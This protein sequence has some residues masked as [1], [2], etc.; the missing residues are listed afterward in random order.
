MSPHTNR[1]NFL[2]LSAAGVAAGAAAGGAA[3]AGAVEPSA[4]S[5]DVTTT[6]RPLQ[7]HQLRLWYP[8][9]A[10]EW[11]EALPIGNGR[12]GA[13]VFGGV[14]SE[15]LQLNEDTVWAGGPYDP[16]NPDGLANLQEIR[17]RVFAG[18]WGG[19]QS[20]ID[21]SF[22]GNPL[23]E[24]P[25]QTVGNLTLTFP[26]G[27]AATDYYR[28]LDL[29][30]A[31][32]LTRYARDGVTYTREA[33][34][35]G[36][37]QVIVVRL[38]ADATGSVSFSAAFDSPQNSSAHSPDPLTIGLDGTTEDWEGVAG[39]VRFRALATVRNTGGTVTSENGTL[40]VDGAD[41]V[42]VLISIGANYT[43]FQDLTGDQDARALD[44][45]LTAGDRAYDVLR[46]RH[47]EDYQRFFNRVALDVGT[48]DA[49]EL[50]TD[51]RVANFAAADDP[52]LVALL[53]QFGRYLLIS[54]SRP[55]TQPANLQGIWNESLSPD[56]DSKYTVNINAEM[57]YWPAGPT[58][59]VEMMEPALQMV[60]EMSVTGARTA[61]VQYGAEGWVCHHNTDAWRGTA[62]VD[63]AQWGMYQTGGAW[64]A[65]F[66]WEHYRFTGD[67]DAL[68]A[69]YPALKGAARF[70]VDALVEDPGTG[71][72]V[73][74]PSNS[75]EN[76]HHPGATVCAGP[77]MDMQ[78]LR[79]LFN[80]VAQAS[81]LLETDADFREQV[82]ALSDRLAPTKVGGQGQIQEWQEDWDAGAPERNHRHVSHLYGLH[83]SNQI[84]PTGTPELAEAARVT[85]EQRGD[86]GTGWSL[87]WKIN[88]WARLADGARSYKLLGDQLTPDRTA[89]NLF[90]LHP[91]FQI[92]G[93][94]GATAG[95]AEWLLQSHTDEIQLLPALPPELPDGQVSGLRARGGDTID[96]TWENGEITQATL[97]TRHARTVQ[98]RTTVPVTVTAADGGRQVTARR[99]DPTTVTFDATAGA[100]YR[101]TRR[102]GS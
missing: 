95:I 34:A 77:T 18:D 9:E 38:T 78:I 101:L 73:T 35:S 3:A 8:G 96:I 22:M 64:M 5:A 31:V 16:A 60:E 70:F 44:P 54:S 99:T 79:D 62:P 67:L 57:N 20:L 91:P 21:S 26:D 29:T 1:R 53:F 93:N 25:Y 76:P 47:V 50:P 6:G 39:Q 14:G 90:C 55:G 89:P 81:T 88:F 82:L 85:L 17:N 33:F 92:D 24:L 4:A 37:D 32:A 42:T 28:E 65:L 66:I 74:C 40:T 36:A 10:A 49:A 12:L 19:A 41:A 30:T 69:R 27:G 87:A 98:V 46:S 43:S 97:H 61:Q 52:Q 45:L 63:G 58:N 11:L 7:E 59:L 2:A 86:A 56:W 48:S 75:P 102:A 51:Q 100:S 84:T 15:R 23:G 83:P 94:F 68:R 13:M 80:A 71:Y 72:M